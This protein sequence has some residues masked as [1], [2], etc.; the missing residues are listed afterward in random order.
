MLKSMKHKVKQKINANKTMK[1]KYFLLQWT[2]L[3]RGIELYVN[4]ILF[5]Y[6]KA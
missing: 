1:V 6:V 2:M 4:L 5:E 3:L